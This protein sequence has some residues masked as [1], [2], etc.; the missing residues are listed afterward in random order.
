MVWIVS[1]AYSFGTSLL[2]LTRLFAIGR[3]GSRPNYPSGWIQRAKRRSLLLPH[4]RTHAFEEERWSGFPQR[5]ETERRKLCLL[6]NGTFLSPGAARG[7]EAIEVTA[8][9]SKGRNAGVNVPAGL[10]Q[11]R[12]PAIFL[13]FVSAMHSREPGLLAVLGECIFPD[14]GNGG[15]GLKLLFST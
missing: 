6:L 12:T 8:R 13:L 10:R 11:K 7:P 5:P 9:E 4:A 15:Y 2:P 1:L 3:S 14:A